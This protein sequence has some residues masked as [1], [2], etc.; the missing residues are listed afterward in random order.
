MAKYF[1]LRFSLRYARELFKSFNFVCKREEN[2]EV[3][4]EWTLVVR[5]LFWFD[6]VTIRLW[7]FFAVF[8]VVLVVV[9]NNFP[10]VAAAWAA[11]VNATQTM[12]M[13]MMMVMTMIPCHAMRSSSSKKKNKSFRVKLYEVVLVCWVGNRAGKNNFIVV[14]K[15]HIV[16]NKGSFYSIFIIRIYLDKLKRFK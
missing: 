10:S 9:D 14:L 3:N 8:C 5:W 1:N 4:D 13:M 12:K 11:V 16:M 7:I 6:V 2:L 15:L